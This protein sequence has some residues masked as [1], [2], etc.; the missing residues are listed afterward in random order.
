MLGL[1]YNTTTM[2]ESPRKLRLGLSPDEVAA[3]KNAVI[4]GGAEQRGLSGER[5]RYHSH[6]G[7]TV[8]SCERGDMRASRDGIYVYEDAGRR[9]MP[10]PVPPTG[11]SMAVDELYQAIVHGRPVLHDGQWGKATLEVCLAILESARSRREV[12]LAHQV[13]TPDERAAAH[14]QSLGLV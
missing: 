9:E 2:A 14:L 10:V 3:R 7:V 6:F 4:Y 8:V 1:F 5:E 11:R 12:S 13:P